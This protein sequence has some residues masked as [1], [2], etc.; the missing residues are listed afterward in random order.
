MTFELF[1]GHI[2]SQENG[3]GDG[4]GMRLH[5]EHML[6]SVYAHIKGHICSQENGVGDGLGMRLHYEHMLE[7]V[8]AHIFVYLSR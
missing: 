5:Y 6:E 1:K 8:Y 4:L 3:V 7:S 2:C